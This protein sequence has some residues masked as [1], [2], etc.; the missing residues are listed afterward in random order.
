[1]LSRRLTYS[2]SSHGLCPSGDRVRA[3]QVHALH[4][5]ARTFYAHFDFE[6]SPADPLHLMLLI[7]DASS[8]VGR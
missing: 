1:M 3:L 5:N 7:K 6:P 4:D 8:I 2:M